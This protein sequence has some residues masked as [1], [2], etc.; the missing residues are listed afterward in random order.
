MDGCGVSDSIEILNK[1]GAWGPYNLICGT[2]T[3]TEWHG[4]PV[5]KWRYTVRAYFG[6]GSGIWLCTDACPAHL[7]SNL[8]SMGFPNDEG[9]TFSCDECNRIIRLKDGVFNGYARRGWGFSVY[10]QEWGCP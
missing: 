7:L 4:N 2:Y 3:S 9:T 1:T 5:G 8:S 6:T 10:I